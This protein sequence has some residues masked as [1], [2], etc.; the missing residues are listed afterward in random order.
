MPRLLW[1]AEREFKLGKRQ[2]DGHTL[3]EH[4]A[5]MHRMSKR[6]HPED[7][8]SCEIPECVAYLWTYFC[9]LSAGR[10]ISQVGAMPIPA[11]EF[12]AWEELNEIKLQRWELGAIRQL[13]ALYLKILN[14]QD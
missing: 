1:F 6:R 5:A 7:R 4:F 8:P 10:I 3:R 14:A 12:R 13:D 11:I 2:S 9:D